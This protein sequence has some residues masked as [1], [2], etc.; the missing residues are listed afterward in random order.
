MYEEY[1]FKTRITFDNKTGK[2]LLLII[3]PWA[4]EY[5]LDPDSTYDI[6]AHCRREPTEEVLAMELHNDK[7]IVFSGGDRP[8]VTLSK[9]GEI[10]G[11]HL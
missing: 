2:P 11:D 7:L 9:D 4:F 3:E 5:M 10:V 8:L 6:V 1:P